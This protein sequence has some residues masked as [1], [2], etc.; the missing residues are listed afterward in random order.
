M[1]AGVP[2]ARERGQSYRTGRRHGINTQEE[3]LS[4]LSVRTAAWKA[5]TPVCSGVYGWL[6]LRMMRGSEGYSDILCQ[7]QG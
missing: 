6:G 4:L 3:A 2:E 7:T 5:D 1:G